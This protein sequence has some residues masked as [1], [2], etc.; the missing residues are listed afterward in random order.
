[1]KCYKD[2]TKEKPCTDNNNDDDEDDSGNDDT[3]DND[4][5][6][7]HLMHELSSQ[8]IRYV[9]SM[10]KKVTFRKLTSTW[11]CFIRPFLSS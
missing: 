4:D 1:M 9:Y 7:L 2:K 11:G 10:G 5:Y 6:F 3:Y 8:R